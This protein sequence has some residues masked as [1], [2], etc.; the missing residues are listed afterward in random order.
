[1]QT[2]RRRAIFAAVVA[3]YEQLGLKFEEDPG[4][5]A[6]VEEWVSGT[7]EIDE[8]QQRYRMLTDMRRNVRSLMR[9]SA[10]AAAPYSTEIEPD[11]S[12]EVG[13]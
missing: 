9:S 4:F 5:Q 6:S 1:M 7:I 2:D 11:P 13:A 12:E 10:V 3:K 8:L